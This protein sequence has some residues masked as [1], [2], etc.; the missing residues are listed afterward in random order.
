MINC[1]W[2][3]MFG[4]SPQEF[5][6]K[7]RRD[8]LNPDINTFFILSW[9]KL[10]RRETRGRITAQHIKTRL[11]FF[12][13]LLDV[14]N[15]FACIYRVM[16]EGIKADIWLCYDFG[17]V[18]ALWVCSRIRGGTV[19]MLLNNQ[20]YV[21]SKTR[22]FGFM[23]SLYSRF[24]EL[25]M[26]PCV[27]KFYTINATMRDYIKNL[28]VPE[29]KIFVFTMDT[30]L[31]EKNLIESAQAGAIKQKYSIP[32]S[33]KVILTVARLEP[34][35][36]YPRLLELFAS[37]G[38]GYVLLCLGRGSL[39]DELKAQCVRLGIEQ[40]V[41]FPGFVHREEIWN[42]Y[43]DADAF[44]LL[45]K[46]EALGV[47]FWEAMYAGVP[48][49]GSDIPGIVETIGGDGDRGRILSDKL[50]GEAFK[51]MITEACADDEHSRHKTQAM[52]DRA[53]KFVESKIHEQLSINDLAP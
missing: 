12:R 29:K 10:T 1:D 7:L 2:R 21:Y 52:T 5:E 41:H 37:L 14:R 19:V 53:K 22:R 33:S 49:I 9:A 4:T 38:E 24:L 8:Q 32:S 45:S 44:V 46:A 23:K 51:K 25:V 20:P 3:D 47:V 30:I 11:G 35:K 39:L 34:E 28:G 18:P 48:C 15:F 42:Y 43:A 31:R 17:F 50:D 26:P 27:D 6:D 16:R 13:P 36:D 40:R